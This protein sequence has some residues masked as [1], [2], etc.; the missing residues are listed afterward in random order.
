[1]IFK[2][3]LHRVFDKGFSEFKRE[4]EITAN[5]QFESQESVE[6]IVIRSRDLIENFASG[7]FKEVDPWQ[8]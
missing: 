5:N 4:S 2:I 6:E 7:N 3:W 8:L 1:M